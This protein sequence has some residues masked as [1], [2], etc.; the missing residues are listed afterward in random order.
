MTDSHPI[1][2]EN[3]HHSLLMQWRIARCVDRIIADDTAH[4][5]PFAAIEQSIT[6]QLPVGAGKPI[7]LAAC[8]DHYYWE[9]ARTMLR[10]IELQGQAERFHIHLCAPSD[11]VL[12]DVCALPQTLANVD[13]SITWDEGYG[14]S[15]P[16]HPA[17]Y[18]TSARFLL[19]PL[20]LDATR[21]PLLCLDIDGIARRPVS[22]AYQTVREGVDAL[23][24]KRPEKRNASRKVLASAVGFNPTANG[25]RFA[26]RLSRALA[27]S[28][29]MRPRYHVDQIVLHR[30]VE[31]LE[32]QLQLTTAQMPQSFADHD[33]RADSAI[34]TAKGWK[35]KNGE[36]Y[37]LEVARIDAVMAERD[38]GS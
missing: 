7:L 9:F 4:A 36:T 1:E 18:Y 15:L 6:G 29:H 20:I 30:I 23:L 22:A 35:R 3:G 31:K 12:A 19:A 8:N 33:F 26:E 14:Q 2:I 17:I 24:I 38:R 21:S 32:S 5:K 16:H 27:A 10:S 25:L 28:L 37:R 34:W 11:E 13:L